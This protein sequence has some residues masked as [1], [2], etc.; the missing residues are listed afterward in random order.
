M[1]IFSC[2]TPSKD[3]DPTEDWVLSRVPMG[4]R[5][6]IQAIHNQG[7][8]RQRLFD[9]G[10]RPQ[11]EVHVLRCAPLADPI[12]VQVGHSFVSLRRDEASKISVMLL[13]VTCATSQ[14]C[15]PIKLA[16]PQGATHD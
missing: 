5:C 11:R 6:V 15:T 10:L 3:T 14:H 8:I 4:R 7:M 1:N 16:T 13:P 9:L 2:F 12:E